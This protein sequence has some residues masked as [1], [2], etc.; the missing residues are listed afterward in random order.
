MKRNKPRAL[1]F[2]E[3]LKREEHVGLSQ[4]ARIVEMFTAVPSNVRRHE[5]QM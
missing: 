1:T 2:L 5:R 4:R 3:K